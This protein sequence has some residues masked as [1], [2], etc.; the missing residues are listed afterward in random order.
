MGQSG[1]FSITFALRL[2][3]IAADLCPLRVEAKSGGKSRTFF[4]QSLYCQPIQGKSLALGPP[5]HPALGHPSGSSDP[6]AFNPHP[7]PI[8]HILY[9]ECF[10]LTQMLCLEVSNLRGGSLTLFLGFLN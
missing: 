1:S 4:L 8:L 2:P 5:P 7:I 9:A 3:R 6:Y 10:P